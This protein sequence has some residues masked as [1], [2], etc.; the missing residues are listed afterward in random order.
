MPDNTNGETM[1]AVARTTVLGRRRTAAAAEKFRDQVVLVIV[2]AAAVAV[3]AEL[4]PG[5][6]LIERLVELRGARR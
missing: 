4:V 1:T 2:N 6:T 5:G 3:T